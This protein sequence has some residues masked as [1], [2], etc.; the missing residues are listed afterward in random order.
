MIQEQS[1]GNCPGSPMLLFCTHPHGV[2]PTPLLKALPSGWPFHTA[3]VAA[4]NIPTAFADHLVQETTGLN[5][6]SAAEVSLQLKEQFCQDSNRS[7]PLRYSPTSEC[8]A[9]QRVR[10]ESYPHR[11]ASLHSTCYQQLH[12]STEHGKGFSKGLSLSGTGLTPPFLFYASFNCIEKLLFK[13]QM[14]QQA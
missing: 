13:C 5:C 11:P 14:Q 9:H 12:P 6:S 7:W 8:T 2:G 10:E 3:P 1:L 4:A